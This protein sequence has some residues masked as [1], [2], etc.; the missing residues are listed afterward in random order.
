MGGRWVVLL[1]GI[2]VGNAKRIAMADLRALVASLGFTEVATV[3][4]SGNVVLTAPAGTTAAA[5]GDRVRTAL[6]DQ[7]GLTTTVVVRT[8]GELAAAV[9]ADPLGPVATDPSRHLLGFPDG[10]V[11]PGI[12]A[13]VAEL[14]APP[15]VVR[16]VAGHLYL[17]CP[18]GVLRSPFA[19]V[20]WPKVLGTT[21][22]M[23]NWNTVTK[24]SALAAG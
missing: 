17:W 1:S 14:A 5:V 21:V 24:L 10:A 15:N 3:L 9:A 23:R 19:T 13:A 11:A 7:A 22:T 16:L 2:N 8:A 20:A 12:G 18:D 4:Q 6:G